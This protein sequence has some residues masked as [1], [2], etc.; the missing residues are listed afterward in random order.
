MADGKVILDL[1]LSQDGLNKSLKEIQQS[2]DTTVTKLNKTTHELNATSKVTSIPPITKDLDLSLGKT[3]TKL[4]GN[5]K[6]MSKMSTVASTAGTALK[7]VGGNAGGLAAALGG[8]TAATAALGGAA[9][10]AG[11]AIAGA[12]KVG[13]PF[14]EQLAKVQAISGATSEEMEQLTEKAKDLGRTTQ[15]SATE[16]AMAFKYMSQAGWDTEN[17]LKAIESVVQL[18]VAS[19]EDLALVADIITDAITG[20]GLAA[21]DAQKFA[22]I[23]ATTA[24]S[25]N[26]NIYE[27]GETFKYVAT[28]SNA[29]GFSVE[30]TAL[31]IGL[32]ANNGLRGSIAGTSL[33]G[34]F[35]K[36]ATASGESK[37]ILKH[38][39]AE[40]ANSDG[41]IKPL[42]EVLDN[43][44]NG[45][46][47]LTQEQ[48]INIAKTLV[49]QESLSGFLALVN[50]TDE[51]VQKLTEA[52]KGASG[53]VQRQADIVGNTVTGKYNEFKAAL[54]GLGIALY[55]IVAPVLKILLKLLADLTNALTVII[56]VTIEAFKALWEG[57]KE[58]GKLLLRTGEIL[59]EVFKAFGLAFKAIGTLIGQF[60]L[61]L[62]EKIKG[63]FVILGK[64][65]MLFLKWVLYTL[66]NYPKKLFTLLDMVADF[67]KNLVKSFWRGIASMFTWLKNKVTGFFKGIFGRGNDDDFASDLNINTSRSITTATKRAIPS[68]TNALN[69]AKQQLEGTINGLITR[70]PYSLATAGIATPTQ[71]ISTLN[72][73]FDK[74]ISKG[75]TA[76]EAF[77]RQAEFYRRQVAN[78]KGEK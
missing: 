14:E 32:L 1:V 71:N 49:G 19:G 43:L 39:N 24:S 10:I 48:Q 61:W 66:L 70:T 28:T 13:A 58:T 73:N 78:G 27:M 26:T 65:L 76:D 21:E 9:A 34:V 44:R 74:Y 50:S 51:D 42:S 55:R 54:E 7:A 59:G 38:F 52:L 62:W 6:L 60:A 56:E 75:S 45:F 77:F 63:L 69:S 17:S 25:S 22:D 4:K 31:A 2:A 20:F 11:V 53:E 40:L 37:E 5:S 23:L 8:A 46:S 16:V 72:I 30:D 57:L 41:T 47:E 3:Q 64:G 36:L 12:I 33:R 68:F 67:G 15:K 35:T 29:L 18:S